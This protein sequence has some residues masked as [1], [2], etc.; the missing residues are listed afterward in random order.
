[1]ANA[2]N[3]NSSSDKWREAF[4]S[5]KRESDPRK[6]VQ[7]LS[8]AEDAIFSRL[9]ELS[10]K[11]PIEHE[12]ISKATKKLRELQVEKLKYPRWEGERG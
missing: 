3:A 4:E 1:M 6:L 12:A 5:A 11:G 2:P 7:L 10:G 8:E 9:Q